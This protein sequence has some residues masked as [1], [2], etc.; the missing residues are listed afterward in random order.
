MPDVHSSPPLRYQHPGDIIIDLSR[1]RGIAI[2]LPDDSIP[3]K[4]VGLR[5]QLSLTD[6]GKAKA[7]QYPP[8]TTSTS[9]IQDV[10]TSSPTSATPQK[11]RREVGEADDEEEKA[12]YQARLRN[13]NPA[14]PKVSSFL[15]GPPLAP[16]PGVS[17]RVPPQDY[18]AS[19][20]YAIN[21]T[22]SEAGSTSI[23][24]DR[25]FDDGTNRTRMTTS[26]SR[27]NDLSSGVGSGGDRPPPPVDTRGPFDHMNLA[28]GPD[29]TDTPRSTPWSTSR[30]RPFDYLTST[31]SSEDV[32]PILQPTYQQSMHSSRGITS[33]PIF[34]SNT[35]FSGYTFPTSNIPHH[36]PHP[37]GEGSS[38]PTSASSLLSPHQPMDWEN[39]PLDHNPQLEPQYPHVYVSFGAGVL[40]K[41]IDMHTAD[42]PVE[43]KK[44]A[45]G[46]VGLIPYHVPT[47]VHS[48]ALL[49]HLSD[50]RSLIASRAA[51]PTGS[52]IMILGGFGFLSRLHGLSVDN[53]VEAEVVL[54]DGSVVIVNEDENPGAFKTIAV[55]NFWSLMWFYGC[56]SLVGNEGC[57]HVLRRYY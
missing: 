53:L 57:W 37:A 29:S 7:N 54:A 33:F 12:A 10:D 51:H 8:Q 2:G 43:A 3:R 52:S 40:Q 17:R 23:G 47:Y 21:S 1:L 18:R 30:A 15:S 6:K 25:Q 34:A 48:C 11:R 46:T 31:G 35:P 44:S 22:G 9:K 26:E 4:Y 42:N 41:E 50:T 56:R 36:P 5:D 19:P 16:E 20:L 49:Y 27:A 38:F 14:A 32:G 39:P 55:G 13:Y 24:V 28:G 45:T